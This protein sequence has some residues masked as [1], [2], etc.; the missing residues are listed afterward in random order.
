MDMSAVVDETQVAATRAP[1]CPRAS[2]SIAGGAGI[3]SNSGLFD[4]DKPIKDYTAEERDNLFDLDDGRKVKVG[5]INLTYEGVV[6]KLKTV[7]GLQGPRDAAA[8]CAGRIRQASSPASLCPACEGAR[9]NAGGAGQQDRRAGTSPSCRP[10]RSADLA[11]FVRGIEAP[12]V[13]PML[14]ALAAR[15]EN[16]VDHRPRLSEPR[17]RKLDACRAARASGS[18]WCAISAPR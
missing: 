13:G 10:C 16:L 2:R 8:A 18:R 1:C 6:P 5:K 15:L 4:L 3:Y 17:P 9:L 11:P 12:Q 7:A 14:D